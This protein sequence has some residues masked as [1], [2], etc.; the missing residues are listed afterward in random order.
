MKRKL[1]TYPADGIT[2]TWDAVRCIHAAECVRGLPDVFDPDR[3]PWIEPGQADNDA[4]AEVVQRCPTGALQFART[5]GGPGE[6]PDT[7]NV[8]TVDADGPIFVR[9]DLRID[10]GDGP[11]VVETRVALCRCGASQA[12]PY[13]DGSHEEAGF[14]DGG[15]IAGGRLVPA[16][17][18]DGAAVDG[19][20]T[21]RR[22]PDGPILVA[23]PLRVEGTDGSV[24]EGVKGALCRCGHSAT[25]PFC[26]GSHRDA[27]FQAD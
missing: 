16:D 2:V 9:G 17:E 3:T 11:E 4:V 21:F 15:A 27:G 10:T 8:A 19:P 14:A 23:G 6:E 13:C 22:T 24:S 25:K 20:V 26:D 12:K 7:R 1:R 5:D 18:V